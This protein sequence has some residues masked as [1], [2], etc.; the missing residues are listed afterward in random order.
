MQIFNYTYTIPQTL[1]AEKFVPQWEWIKSIF[2]VQEQ[3]QTKP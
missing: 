2:K 3:N 1:L